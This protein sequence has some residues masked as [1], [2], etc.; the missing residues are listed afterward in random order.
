MET[1]LFNFNNHQVSVM[2]NEKNETMFVAKDVCEIL[3]YKNTS[4]A[5]N[6]H[7]DE[8][9]RC[10]ISLERGGSQILI[11][12]SGLYSLV[13]RSKKPEAK[14]FK[15][16][17]T[18]E[19]LPS[20]R[21]NGMYANQQTLEQLLASPDFAIKTLQKLKDEQDYNRTLQLEKELLQEVTAKQEAELQQSAPMVVYYQNVLA[22]TSTYLTNQIAKEFGYAAHGFNKLLKQ[23]GIQYKQGETWVL[24]AK[25]QN[26]GYTQTR[27]FSFTDSHGQTKTSMS[28]V[29]TEAGRKFLHDMVSQKLTQILTPQSATS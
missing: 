5:I 11:N 16:W 9:D 2:I 27:T 13:L 12:E 25:Y 19:V 15:K 29:W 22:S 3:A 14:V 24:T 18:S 21:K 8:D 4:K 28:T 7:T 6:D 26:K 23:S 17:V 1:Q 20:I 10:N